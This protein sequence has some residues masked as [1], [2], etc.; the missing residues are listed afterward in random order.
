MFLY[1]IVSLSDNVII[2]I[3][4]KECEGNFMLCV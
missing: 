3:Q 4:V 2:A 1:I